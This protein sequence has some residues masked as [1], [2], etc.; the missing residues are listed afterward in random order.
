MS[1]IR[2]IKELPQH[3]FH[4]PEKVCETE[5]IFK[6]EIIN[7]NMVGMRLAGLLGVIGPLFAIL[8]NVLILGHRVSVFSV[9]KVDPTHVGVIWDELVIVL[10]GF[11]CIGLSFTR[12]GQKWGRLWVAMIMIIMLSVMIM[13]EVSA[14]INIDAKDYALS[15]TML[16]LI[17][18]GTMPYRPLQMLLLGLLLTAA[19]YFCVE[20]FPRIIDVPP[21]HMNPQY[22]I[23]IAM[24]TLFCTLISGLIYTNRYKQF[25]AHRNEEILRK[26]ALES[27]RKYRALFENSS[28]G[29]FAFDNNTRLFTM[30]NPRVSEILGYDEGDMSTMPFTDVIHP[31]DLQR[32]MAYHKARIEGKPAPMN[33]R[34]KLNHKDPGKT[35]ICDIA[36]HR[37]AD[38]NLTTGAIRDVTERVR[39]EEQ[40]ERL[41]Q[42]PETNPFPV[43]RFDYCGNIL[44]MNPSAKKLPKRIGKADTPV[45]DLMP[46]NFIEKIQQLIDEDKTVTFERIELFDKTFTMTYRPLPETK[47]IFVWMADITDLVYAEHRIQVYTAELEDAN[48][49]LRDTQSQLVQSEKMAALGNLVAGVAH[50]IN[51]PLGSISANADVSARALEILCKAMEDKEVLDA[52]TSH[53][54]LQQAVKIINESNNTTRIASKRIVEIVRSLRNF[55]RLDEAEKNRVNVHDGIDSTL[56]LIQHEIKQRIEIIKNYGDVPDIECLPNQLNQVFMNILMNSAQAIEDQGTIT[57]TTKRDGDWVVMEFADD[58][59]G[60]PQES[61]VRIFDPGFTTKGVGVGTGLGL[62]ISYRIIQEHGG[63]IDASSEVGKGTIFTVKLPVR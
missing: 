44:Y 42:F 59:K 7:L 57:I 61:L 22:Y 36:V 51:S 35:V 33:Y 41:A 21:I 23:A 63:S 37:I 9:E 60:I 11:V 38:P 25:K 4:M 46:D 34:I 12:T 58:G 48:H 2:V 52:F 39:M 50:E 28:D 13:G 20:Q 15:F 5:T 47:Q 54:K 53:P 29:V 40:I 19:Y 31:D 16:M 3:I 30:I 32:A 55:A 14:G 27:E 49:E 18:M 56:M 1:V 24:L 8:A 10:L 45:I 17:A 26:Q 43:L 6:E 62:S